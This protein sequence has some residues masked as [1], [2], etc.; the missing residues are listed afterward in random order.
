MNL[1]GKYFATLR[2]DAKTPQ[3]LLLSKICGHEYNIYISFK[4]ITTQN[5]IILHT[6]R[7]IVSVV[8]DTINTA[9]IIVVLV[10]I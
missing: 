1:Q 7:P 9:C 10:Y 3:C 5:T 8:I 4:A 2:S 6:A